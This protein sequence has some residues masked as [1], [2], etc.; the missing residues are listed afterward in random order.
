MYGCKLKSRVIFDF[1]AQQPKG[2]TSSF[3]SRY[4]TKCVAKLRDLPAVENC[5]E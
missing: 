3:Y 4:E 1:E 5:P 2:N